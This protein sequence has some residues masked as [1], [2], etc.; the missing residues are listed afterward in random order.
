MST[1]SWGNK[2]WDKDQFW[3]EKDL[4]EFYSNFPL[5]IDSDIL[6]FWVTRTIFQSTN[7]LEEPPFK[8]IY[9]HALAEDEQGRKMSKSPGNAIDPNGSVKIYSADILRSTLALLAV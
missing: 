2:D 1:L 4:R 7:A 3:F 8:Y 5:I 9:L 6:S